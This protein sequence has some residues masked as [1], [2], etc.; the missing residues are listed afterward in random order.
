MIYALTPENRDL[1]RH[2]VEQ[3]FQLR[4]SIFV[5]EK[6]WKEFERQSVYEMDQY[7][8]EEAI[9]LLAVEED[10]VFAGFRLYPTVR[11]HMLSSA[12]PQ[13][14]EGKIPQGPDILEWSRIFIVREKRDSGVY[15]ELGSAM[16]EFCF[17]RNI[18]SVTAV[19]QMA[20]LA[21]MRNAGFAVRPLGLPKD[22]GGQ[23]FLAVQVAVREEALEAVR[24]AGDIQGPVIVN[25]I[26][27]PHRP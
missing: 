8:D 24:R 25:D 21:V 12:F 1:Y 19:I 15:Y 7:D 10:R 18:K 9:Y 4:H 20:R 27:A 23:P 14:V 13:L 2:F 26:P 6:G 16:H 22:I 17:A 3:Q 11:S 5:K